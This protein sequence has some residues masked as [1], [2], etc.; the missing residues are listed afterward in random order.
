[1]AFRVEIAPAAE[2][3]IR[4]LPQGVRERLEPVILA[5]AEDPRPRGVRKIR[6]TEYCYRLRVGPYRV[7]YDVLDAR[8]LA[9]VLGVGR[10]TESTYRGL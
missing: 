6:G 10:R 2:R 3:D 4:R 9:I 7:I 5:L 1:M 8:Q